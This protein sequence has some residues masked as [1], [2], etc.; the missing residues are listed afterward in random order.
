MR[1]L[2]IA[3]FAL[4]LIFAFTAPAYAVDTSFSG[5]FRVRGFLDNNQALA[6]EST[7]V[8]NTDTNDWYNQRLR[9]DMVFK[10]ADGLSITNRFHAMDRTV[11]VLETQNVAPTDATA[12]NSGNIY[13]RRAYMTFKT[14]IGKFDL[15]YM[16][17]GTWGTIFADTEADG[18][19]RIKYT[20]VFGQWIVLAL[21]EKFK[22][23]D[24]QQVSSTNT[25]DADYDTYAA[26]GIYKWDGGN[27]GLLYYYL[28]NRMSRVSADTTSNLNVLIPYFKAN[29]GP[30]YLE[31]EVLYCFGP[32]TEYEV[33]GAGTD[34]DYDGWSWY[35]SGKYNMGPAYVGALYGYVEGDDP[36]TTDYEAGYKG[37]D[38][39]PCLILFNDDIPTR[40]NYNETYSS[41]NNGSIVQVN[42]GFSPM[43]NL[44]LFASLSYA[45]ADEK[46]VMTSAGV[47]STTAAVDDEIGTEIDITATYMIFDN[48]EYMIGFGYLMAGDWYKG[49]DST[50][51]IDDGYLIMHKIQ[52]NF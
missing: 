16:S 33:S 21:T 43:E 35:L 10:V 38:W 37:S 15:G 49:S 22:E 47:T 9:V 41:L 34:V 46:Y 3:L 18:R 29:F 23:Q 52:M 28:W 42:A 19:W 12:S 1:K 51:K 17:G 2:L 11:G 32:K 5:H 44:K 7:G 8:A 30:L 14:G 40:G 20:G 39:N 6:D 50:N 31:G 13:W 24:Y 4:G 48:L 36:T 27:A 26:A 25:T 45:W